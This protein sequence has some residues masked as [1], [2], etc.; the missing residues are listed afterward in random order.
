MKRPYIQFFTGDWLKDPRLSLCKPASRGVWIDLLCA[1]HELDQS[2]EL[3]GTS[4]ELARL[5]RCS[6]VE[7]DLALTDLQNKLAANICI[8]RN[9][10]WSIANRRMKK[11]RDTQ[12]K[13]ALAG[14]KGGSK[15][16][17]SREQIPEYEDEDEGKRKVREFCTSISIGEKDADWFFWKCHANGWRNNGQPILDWKGTLRSWQKAGYLPSQKAGTRW[18]PPPKQSIMN[19]TPMRVTAPA[20]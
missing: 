8:H 6:T 4:E 12:E 3:C 19:R 2:G 15:T 13:R 14:S 20:P 16:Q 11:E 18:N 9:G 5:A 17:A 7:L 10:S 1:M